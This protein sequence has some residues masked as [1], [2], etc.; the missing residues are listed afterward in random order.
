MSSAHVEILV[1]R[2]F[3]LISHRLTV[4]S[5]IGTNVAQL[6]RHYDG[7]NSQYDGFEHF[8]LSYSTQRR[9]YFQLFQPS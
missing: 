9:N 8:F 5:V 1:A 7:G 2:E 6:R 3:L 4:A